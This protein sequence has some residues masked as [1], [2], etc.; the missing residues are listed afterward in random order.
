MFF[1]FIR[2]TASTFI[3]MLYSGDG[4]EAGRAEAGASLCNRPMTRDGVFLMKKGLSLRAAVR[5]AWER[6]WGI[7]L[8]SNSL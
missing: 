4:R 5:I 6:P 2:S 3:R 1:S 7:P 8:R